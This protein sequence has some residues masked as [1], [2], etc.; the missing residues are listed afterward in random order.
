MW[1]KWGLI[2]VIAMSLGALWGIDV[3]LARTER[4]EV[5]GE[6]QQAYNAGVVLSN[7]GRA[8]EALDPLRK[9]HALDRTNRR[10][11]LQLAAALSTSG[12]FDEAEHLLSDLLERKPNDGETNL[13]EARLLARQLEW[14]NAFAYYHRAIYGSWDSDAASR[15]QLIDVR[16]ELANLIAQHGAQ[17]DLLA[18]VLPLETEAADNPQVSRQV[19]RLYLTAGSPARAEPLY[20]ALIRSDKGDFELYNGLGDAEL[21]LGNYRSAAATFQ[22]AIRNGGDRNFIE[23]KIQLA[24]GVAD[25]DPTMRRLTST[26]KFNRSVRVL[27]LTL[28]AARRCGQSD[29][30]DPITSA[31]KLLLVRVHGNPTNELAE[32]R[33]TAAETLWQTRT[34]SCIES[35]SAA[36]ERLSLVMAKIGQ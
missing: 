15:N 33:L 21:A 6:A 5:V 10:Y 28:D 35:G 22:D 19:A 13:T 23:Q 20:R 25:L 26:E 11:A 2:I 34:K 30:G 1:G 14:E 3:V 32:E 24:A 9:A 17:K 7:A 29:N 36:D 12:K 31:E 4:A 18:E 16:L 27:Q 8:A